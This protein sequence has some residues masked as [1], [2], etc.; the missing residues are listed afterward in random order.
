MSEKIS[1]VPEAE[2][3]IGM[4]E[5]QWVELD[6]RVPKSR[7]ENYF[8]MEKVEQL[9][10]YCRHNNIRVFKK[11]YMGKIEELEAEIQF[12]SLGQRNY[13]IAVKQKTL[14]QYITHKIEKAILRTKQR[15]YELRDKAHKICPGNWEQK[16]AQGQLTQQ[17]KLK[18]VQSHIIQLK[19][20]T[21]LNSFIQIYIHCL[22]RRLIN[23][24]STI[25]FPKLGQ[26][27][28][29]NLDLPFTQKEIEK[30]LGSLQSN[31]SPGK[32]SFTPEY[33]EFK[34]LLIHSSRMWLI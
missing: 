11:Y 25:E 32:D 31:K 5:D 4:V 17:F 2:E 26:G 20:M 8:L 13:I 7:K 19:L 1:W 16:K 22:I 21:H 6:S 12:N 24:S 33:R 23:F 18:R 27:D 28:Q 34:D 10:N 3:R 14:I 30:A 9:E 15:Y 29:K